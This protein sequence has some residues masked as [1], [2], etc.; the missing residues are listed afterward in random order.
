VPVGFNSD[1][2]LIQ[3]KRL[4][5]SD[6]SWLLADEG[7]F[8]GNIY[9]LQTAGEDLLPGEIV[10]SSGNDE[11][12]KA[13][14]SDDVPGTENSWG[15]THIAASGATDVRVMCMGVVT[16][17]MASGLSPSIGDPIYLSDNVTARATINPPTTP[18]HYIVPLGNIVN[19]DDYVGSSRARAYW[20]P[21]EPREI[22]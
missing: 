20:N 10:Y 2:K 6:D 7:I 11:V 9:A 17:A 16:V 19:L 1:G 8:G 3:T 4:A 15:V 14:A 22:S 18:G 13:I 12:S 5:A 21:K